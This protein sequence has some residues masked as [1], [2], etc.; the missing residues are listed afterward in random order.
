MDIGGTGIYEIDIGGIGIQLNP[1]KLWKINC[2]CMKKAHTHEKNI[3]KVI[4]YIRQ[5]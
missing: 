5:T 2:I 4:S 3:G 1:K